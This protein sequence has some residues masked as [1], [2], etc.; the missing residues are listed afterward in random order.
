MGLR[1]AS[2]G[3]RPRTS[4]AA[5]R[6][7]RSPIVSCPR[8]ASVPA[9]L[10]SP[11][12]LAP[13]RRSCGGSRRARP[14]PKRTAPMKIAVPRETARP[15][16]RG[17]RSRRRSPASSSPTASRCS[18]RPAPARRPRACD[19]AYR[20]AGATHRP[21]RAD[22]LRPGGHGAARRPALRRGDRDA[23]V[24]DRPDRDARARSPTRSSRRAPRRARGHRH[25]HGRHPAHHPRAGDGHAL[26]LQAT[27]GGYKAVLHRG[28]AAAEVHAAADHR[29]GHGPPGARHRHGRRRGRAD[30]D[31][32]RHG[33]WARWS[34]PPTCG[35][36]SRS[37]SS[38][39]AAPSS[40][41]R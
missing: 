36:S 37:R 32:H 14:I 34:R 22:A 12:R 28:R 21:R 25:Q 2:A 11:N 9:T 15:A 38:R 30:G 8:S 3:H 17:S 26:E 5:R 4:A 41:S 18:S 13:S 16:R 7:A 39:W 31:R 33:A 29:R 20:E 19:E 23:A 35:R 1:S 40:R 6:A 24:R 27:V 10:G